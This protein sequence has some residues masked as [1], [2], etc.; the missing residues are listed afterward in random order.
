MINYYL[1]PLIKLTERRIPDLIGKNLDLVERKIHGFADIRIIYY[2]TDS[3]EPH[4][5][6]LEFKFGR[7]NLY[8]DCQENSVKYVSSHKK[9]FNVTDITVC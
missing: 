3:G 5:M 1:N 4:F 9:D 7:I 8:V 2:N 6:T